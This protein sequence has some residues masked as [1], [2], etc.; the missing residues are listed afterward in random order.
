MGQKTLYDAGRNSIAAPFYETL[1]EP[2][3]WWKWFKEDAKIDDDSESWTL[4]KK[5]IVFM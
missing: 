5:S 3:D 1:L 4:V 2:T